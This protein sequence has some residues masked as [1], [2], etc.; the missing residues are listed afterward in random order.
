MGQRRSGVGITGLSSSA[1]T[2]ACSASI[3]RLVAA[4]D[5]LP[6]HD[7]HW[8]PPMRS[9]SSLCSSNRV[10]SAFFVTWLR[11]GSGPL[12]HALH[13][14]SGTPRRVSAR[15]TASSDPRAGVC[16]MTAEADR[17]LAVTSGT[18]SCAACVPVV[19]DI[20][21]GSRWRAPPL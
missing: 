21:I 13:C 8:P 1:T 6:I 12:I 10:S 16:L 3:S 4:D 17:A 20:M 7:D 9:E 5:Y 11:A 15:S 14:C 2:L 19:G 18:E